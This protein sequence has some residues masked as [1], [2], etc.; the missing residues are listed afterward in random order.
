VGNVVLSWEE[1]KKAN[2]LPDAGVFHTAEQ[3]TPHLTE[4][5][6]AST[7]RS[8][9]YGDPGLERGSIAGPRHDP[10]LWSVWRFHVPRIW[11]S[12]IVPRA[13]AVKRKSQNLANFFFMRPYL[14]VR[15]LARPS[16]FLLLPPLSFL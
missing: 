2:A 11:M 7:S 16:H 9:F 8:F 4:L 13:M 14:V 5:R 3:L 1:H 12:S 15:F 10:R 6:G